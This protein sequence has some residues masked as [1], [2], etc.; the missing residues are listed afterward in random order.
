MGIESY[1]TTPANNNSAPPNGAPEGM[2]ASSFNDTLRQIMADS[3][4]QW[5]DEGWFNLG[6]TVAYVAADQFK[7]TGSDVTD[8]YRAG[9]RVRAVGSSTGTIYGEISA[10]A[11]VTDTTITV[12]W[13]TGALANESLTVSVS[14]LGGSESVPATTAATP[15]RQ[16]F[17]SGSGTYTTPDDVTWIEVEL[18]GAGGGGGGSGDGDGGTGG[19]GANTTFST[20]TGSGGGGGNGGTSDSNGALGGAG[21]VASGGDINIPGGGGDS[22]GGLGVNNANGGSGGNGFFGG[23]GR[24]GN[25]TNAGTAG[26]ANSG[27]GGGG[28]GQNVVVNPGAGGGSGGYVRKIITSPAATYS[29]S[30]G[31]AGTAGTAGTSGAV[32]GAGAAGLILVTEHYT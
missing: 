18:I 13:D 3:R 28:A 11:F 27:A 2:A 29:Y 14:F 6:H 15:T 1:S 19:T 4:V 9:R 30:V 10:S 24:G 31:A 26:A 25:G 17:T 21:G 23:G 20:L 8:F 16:V 22:T 5:E 12:V 7:I 32:G